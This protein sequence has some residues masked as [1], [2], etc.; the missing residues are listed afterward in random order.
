MAVII[1]EDCIGCDACLNEC[2]NEAISNS[3][4]TDLDIY[5]INHNRCSECVGSFEE[6]QCIDVCPVDCITIDKNHIE[7][8]EQLMN[9]FL[10]LAELV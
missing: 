8:K 2:P 7:T 5:F 4:D 10:S 6:S 9:K 3:A 1:T